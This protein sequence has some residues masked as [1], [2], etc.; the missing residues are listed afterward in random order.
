VERFKTAIVL[1]PMRG[2][3]MDAEALKQRGLLIHNP[4]T[5]E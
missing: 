1:E 2:D 3:R 4:L 5:D